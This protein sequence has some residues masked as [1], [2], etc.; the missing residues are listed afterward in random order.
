MTSEEF[1]EQLVVQRVIEA[2]KTNLP[3]A[4][5]LEDEEKA[6][7]EKLC[8]EHKQAYEKLREHQML[9]MFDEQK[10]IYE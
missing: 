1:W 6:F 8:P 4:E 3:T 7:L 5:D 10:L 9:S 2:I